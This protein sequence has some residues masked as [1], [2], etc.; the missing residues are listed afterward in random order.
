MI[1]SNIDE[2]KVGF[3]VCGGYYSETKNSPSKEFF[4]QA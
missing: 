4:V 1:L 2:S 3:N